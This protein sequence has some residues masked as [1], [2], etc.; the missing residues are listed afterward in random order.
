MTRTIALAAVLTITALTPVVAQEITAEERTACTADYE[1]YCR[2]TFPGG[3]RI[4]ACL[5]KHYAE[6]GDACKKVV[7]GYKK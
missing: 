4:L 1:K 7:D 6:L 3:G 5:R 2:G